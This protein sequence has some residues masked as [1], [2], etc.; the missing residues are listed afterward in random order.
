MENNLAYQ[1]K[2]NEQLKEWNVLVSLLAEKVENAAADVKLRYAQE[3]DVIK[4][5]QHEAANKIKE[6]ENKSGD[7]WTIAKYTAN[8]G[9]RNLGAGLAKAIDDFK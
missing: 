8:K 6:L 7:A 2:M 9:L 3:Y 1:Q 5:T 4:A